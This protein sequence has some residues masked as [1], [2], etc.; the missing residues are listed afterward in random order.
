MKKTYIKPENI[1]VALDVH[2]NMMTGSIQTTNVEGLSNGGNSSD[3][4][5][6]EANARE[7]IHTHDVWEEW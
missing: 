7:I 4:E 3:S 2:D 1:I 6:F 5:I